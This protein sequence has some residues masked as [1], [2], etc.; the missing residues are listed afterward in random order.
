VVLK[1]NTINIWQH[2]LTRIYSSGKYSKGNKAFM[3]RKK[4]DAWS[5][6]DLSHNW[7]VESCRLK[8]NIFRTDRRLTILNSQIKM[9]LVSNFSILRVLPNKMYF[10]TL[11]SIY[12]SWTFPPKFADTN[13]NR[14]SDSVRLLLTERSNIYSRKNIIVQILSESTY[15]YSNKNIF[16]QESQSLFWQEMK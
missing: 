9:M 14:I 15:V 16:W 2:G 6:A 10:V 8:S 4:I 11:C 1:Y 13:S 7:N 3:R 5:K 12:L